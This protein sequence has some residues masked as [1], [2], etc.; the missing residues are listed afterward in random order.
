MREKILAQLATKFAGVS[1]TTLGLIADKLS[2]RVTD[3]SGIEQ[4]ITDFDNAVSVQEFANDIQRESDRRVGEA[5]RE[6]EKKPTTKKPEKTEEDDEGNSK[7][8]LK[9]EAPEWA[10]VLMGK[11]ESL[12]KEKTQ[13]TI[14]EKA[15]GFLKEI[16][17]KFW[18]GRLLPENEE[19][20]QGFVEAV[21]KDYTDFKQE[22]VD[23]G[24]SQATPPGGGGVGDTVK[25]KEKVVDADIE[26][27]ADKGKKEDNHSKK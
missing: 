10:K 15:T 4:A 19:D 27:W 13:T 8:P 22:M 24:F 25:G 1:K 16:P 6:W 23:Q 21:T 26:A 18:N 3:E 9:D 11:V 2:K 20:L 12:T 17:A 14:K 5:R 7:K